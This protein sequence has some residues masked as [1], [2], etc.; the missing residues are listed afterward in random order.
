VEIGFYFFALLCLALHCIASRIH[1]CTTLNSQS[2]WL[3]NYICITE[4]RGERNGK[5]QR[6]IRDWKIAF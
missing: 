4:Y 1:L 2:F 6:E 3:E 5:T